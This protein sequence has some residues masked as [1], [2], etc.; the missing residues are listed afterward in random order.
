M[1]R[2]LPSLNALR[3]FEAA[4]RH[5]SFKRAAEELHVTPA[6]ISHQIKALE[7]ELG[8]PLFRRLNRLLLLTDA[9]Q[10]LLPGASEGFDRLAEAVCRLGQTRTLSTLVVSVAPSFASKWLVPRLERFAAA[11]PEIDVRVSASITPVDLHRDPVDIAIR[12]GF[13]R[14]PGLEVTKL[15][16]EAVAPLCA[17]HLISGD[18]PLRRLEDLRH[19]TLL[20]D[21]SAEFHGVGTR[22]DWRM[23]LKAAGVDGVDTTRGPHFSFAD[24]A[25]Q[26]A[27]EGAGVAL[28]QTALA[29]GDL[30]AGHL[31]M[32]FALSLPI[33]PAYYILTTEGLLR[34]RPVGAFRDWVLAEVGRP[35]RP[36][37]D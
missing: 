5:L 32:P 37:K 18:P 29:Q 8:Q 20:H 12:F 36:T 3:A 16:D 13:G 26:A 28:S 25:I 33:D 24:H 35:T 4:A 34:R 19:H 9:G 22:P 2:R 23:W 21:D 6:A 1:R 10:L 15:F 7:E 14:Y 17:P 30:E 11:H 31:V 27:I